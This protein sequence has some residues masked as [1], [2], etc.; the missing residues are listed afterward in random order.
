L[1]TTGAEIAGIGYPPGE[2]RG[3]FEI[4]VRFK[5]PTK[6]AFALNLSYQACNESACLPPATRTIEIGAR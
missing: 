4:L 1:T 3:E 5:S 6:S 2:L